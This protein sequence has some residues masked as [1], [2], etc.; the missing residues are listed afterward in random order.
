MMTN[1][2][3]AF[4]Q[5]ENAR[6]EP[7][8]AGSF[9]P[10]D[11]DTL[12]AEVDGFLDAAQAEG[13]DGV[14]AVIVPHAGYVFSGATAAE[15]FARIDPAT[16][17]KRVFLLGPSHRASFDGASVNSSEKSIFRIDPGATVTLF[18]IDPAI[19]SSRKIQN[20]SSFLTISKAHS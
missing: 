20:N 6:R 19:P 1:I 18:S 4:S 13:T 12:R 7:A 11:A 14:Q 8:V 17:Y 5:N 15:A 16:R 2:H 10:A 9:Y 3:S